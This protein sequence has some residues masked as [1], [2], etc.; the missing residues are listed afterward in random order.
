[1]SVRKYFVEFLTEMLEK[2]QRAFIVE[3][4]DPVNIKRG[5]QFYLRASWPNADPIAA[6]APRYVY[7]K[8]GAKPVIV[9]TRIVSYIGEEFALSIFANPTIT[10]AT[11]TVINPSNLNRINPQATTVT[12]LKDPTVT[13]DGTLIDD[14]P[15]YYFGGT[16]GIFRDAN[17]IPPESERI[18]PADT[19]FLVKIEGAGRFSYRLEW[20][21]G[22]PESF[23]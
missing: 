7:F 1:M 11:G 16:T 13:D 12:A 3:P 5:L 22:E 19:E 18:I 6:N 17:S 20:F 10:P 8:T 15:E 21:E 23:D 4:F 2:G 9:K 14:E